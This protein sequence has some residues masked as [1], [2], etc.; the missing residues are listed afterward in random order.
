MSGFGVG[1]R[2][3]TLS[4]IRDIPLYILHGAADRVVPPAGARKTTAA[5]KKLGIDHT[6]VE[7]KGKGHA[8]GKEPFVPLVRW[9]TKQPPKAWSPRPLLF[10]PAVKG[11]TPLWKAHADP[12]GLNPKDQILELIRNGKPKEARALLAKPH[13]KTTR[14]KHTLYV[15]KALTYVP[16]LLDEFPLSLEPKDFDASKGWTTKP[17]TLAITELSKALRAKKG[18][19][20]LA[21]PFDSA[22]RRMLA[23]IHA[24]R[25]AV[26][27]GK[28]DPSWI[29]H[30][31]RFAHYINDISQYGNMAQ[32]IHDL[33]EAVKKR[34]P[35][36]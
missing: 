5:L 35:R 12:L 26:A 19:A 24:K 23:K 32:D 15:L 25:F 21:R 7:L 33:V 29:T 22:G 1:L 10:P 31:N 17:E 34:L 18:T 27:A 14:S 28:R 2:S 30:Y 36:H 4:R 11:A 13:I 6:Y 3:T 20:S 8:L 9:I 16:G